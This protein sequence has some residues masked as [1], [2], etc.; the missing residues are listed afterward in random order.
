MSKQTR[1]AYFAVAIGGA[2]GALAR[3]FLSELWPGTM[4][5]IPVALV[6]INVLG[7]GLLAVVLVAGERVF[8]P[9]HPQ[10]HMWR[11]FMAT[12]VL[13]GFTTTSAFAGVTAEMIRSGNSSTALIFIALSVGLGLLAFHTFEKITINIVTVRGEE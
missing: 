9:N 7:S 3:L 8:A 5:D 11:P 13:G 10:H 2:S 12:G 4:W 6:L 1:D